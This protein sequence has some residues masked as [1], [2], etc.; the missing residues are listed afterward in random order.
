MGE[1]YYVIFQPIDVHCHLIKNPEG[2][3]W[4]NA[5]YV[6]SSLSLCDYPE[7]HYLPENFV[8]NGLLDLQNCRNLKRLPRTLKAT[9][10]I[11]LT[12]CQKITSIPKH[13]YLKG[14]LFLYGCQSLQKF[15][16]N[17]HIQGSVYFGRR[18]QRMYT[19]PT[20]F[21]GFKYLKQLSENFKVENNLDLNGCYALKDLPRNLFVGGLLT[22]N[23]CGVLHPPRG[24][25][26][27]HSFST[28]DQIRKKRFETWIKWTKSPSFQICLCVLLARK[29]SVWSLLNDDIVFI[30]FKNYLTF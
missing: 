28:N 2:N 18:L 23:D 10:M 26:F 3:D 1:P 15:P 13:F 7:M 9:G 14:D 22:I 4:P 11:N 16:R 27:I 6:T 25:G 12:G 24:L 17:F 19:T 20:V 21:S 5:V 8:V 30:L 29:V